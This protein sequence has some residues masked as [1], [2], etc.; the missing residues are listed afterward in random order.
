MTTISDM[1]KSCRPGYLAI[2]CLTS[3][4]L[5]GCATANEMQLRH[6]PVP[7]KI[8]VMQSPSTIKANKLQKVLAPQTKKK[9]TRSAPA[10]AQGI[11]HSRKYAMTSM[12]SDL[13]DQPKLRLVTPPA[14]E[15]PLIEKIQDKRFDSVISQK[16]ADQ[17]QTT[18]GAD[19]ILRFGITDYGLTPNSWRSGYITF[20]VVSTLAITA[21]IASAG[22]NLAK[23]AAGAYLAQETVEETAESYA[24][25]WGLDVVCRPV[26]IEAE[27]IQLHPVKV[28]WTDDD[29]GLSD[30]SLSRL[31]RK[32]GP[33]E[34]NMQLDQA[35]GYAVRD[36]LADLSASIGPFKPMHAPHS[37]ANGK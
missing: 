18:T 29:T 14:D 27:L 4:G 6:M 8:L 34:R 24:G 2:L 5:G 32:V 10:L 25:F 9:L 33:P 19:A 21:V 11:K 3:I 16:T 15:K 26:R 13:R 12:V 23:G 31:T 1:P 7:V 28:I 36:I 37:F 20:E 30:V 17:I 22:T 35:T